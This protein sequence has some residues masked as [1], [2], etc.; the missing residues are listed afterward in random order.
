MKLNPDR[1]KTPEE[2]AWLKGYQ[3]GVKNGQAQWRKPLTDEQIRDLLESEFLGGPGNRD[4][5]D[6]I[7]IVRATEAAHGIK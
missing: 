3:Q 6:D 5:Q 2:R 1:D 7:R 4:L